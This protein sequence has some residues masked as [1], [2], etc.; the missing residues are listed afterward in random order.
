MWGGTWNGPY[1]PQSVF[2]TYDPPG[3]G[4]PNGGMTNT[5]IGEALGVVAGLGAMGLAAVDGNIGAFGVA[6]IGTIGAMSVSIGENSVGL[7]VG[8]FG[9]DGATGSPY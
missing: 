8:A 6:T 5:S 7:G 3:N 1:Q 4:G 9:T 2:T